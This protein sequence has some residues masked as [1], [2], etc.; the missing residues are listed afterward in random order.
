MA[1]KSNIRLLKKVVVCILLVRNIKELYISI[2]SVAV[3]LFFYKFSYS[4]G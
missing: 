2:Y 4:S 3:K 1:N